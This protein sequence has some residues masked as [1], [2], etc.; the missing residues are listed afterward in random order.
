MFARG[1]AGGGEAPCVPCTV[2]PFLGSQRAVEAKYILFV[3]ASAFA[4]SLSLP[5][6]RHSPRVAVHR[7]TCSLEKSSP[8]SLPPRHSGAVPL[9]RRALLSLAAATAAAG[10]ATPLAPTQRAGASGLIL[11]PLREALTNE[12]Y[13]LRSGESV[14]LTGEKVARTNPVEKTSLRYHSLTRRGVEQMLEAAAVLENEYEVGPASWIWASQ[15]QSAQEAAH[16]IAAS[17]GIRNEQVVPEFS[18]LDS[19]GVGALEGTS[20]A[21]TD[22]LLTEIDRRNPEERMAPGEDGTPNESAIDV[23]V[24]VRQ[25]LAKLETQYSGDQILV[26]A[27][28]SDTLTVL[29]ASLSNRP[30][31]EHRDL[32]YSPGELRRIEPVVVKRT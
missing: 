26:V 1:E 21:A 18:F 12:Y 14:H 31:T 29:E 19:R 10:L 8:P 2:K 13:F 6:T 22:A 32:R 7:V 23:F 20:L 9:S 15:N 16:I 28:D 5:A 27:P 24:R 17:L 3:M 25:L 11:F 30:L 4:S